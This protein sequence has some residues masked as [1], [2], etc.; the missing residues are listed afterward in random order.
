MAEAGADRSVKP[1]STA[2]SATKTLSAQVSD[3]EVDRRQFQQMRS[4][5]HKLQDQ[6]RAR[7]EAIRSE[8][9]RLNYEEQQEKSVQGADS[10]GKRAGRPGASRVQTAAC[11]PGGSTKQL[12]GI[13]TQ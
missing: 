3:V 9:E 8:S 5:L 7:K 2:P 4:E 11:G 12:D 13:W 10:D 1:H 6:Y